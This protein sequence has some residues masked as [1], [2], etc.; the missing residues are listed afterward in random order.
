MK[1]LM[2]RS[3]APAMT[4]A[5]KRAFMESLWERYRRYMFFTAR[6][7]T[8]QSAALEDIVSES[9]LRLM[10][11]AE[12]LKRLSPPQLLLY[13]RRTVRSQAVDHARRCRREAEFDGRGQAA[14][15]DPLW[16]GIEL[17]EELTALLDAIDALDEAQRRVLLLR[18]REKRSVA[19]I[20][21]EIGASQ[22]T[23][24]RHLADAR[25]SLKRMLYGDGGIGRGH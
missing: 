6:E 15:P 14:A 22:S 11:K 9:L 20:A 25:Q 2:L 10:Q 7:Y 1:L 8:A 18:Y 4:E 19:E 17:E 12:T 13:I 21:E 16:R 23:V 3:H 24:R 5:E